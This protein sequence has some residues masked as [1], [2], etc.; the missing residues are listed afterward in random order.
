MILESN[1]N[2]DKLGS[3][4]PKPFS[5]DDNP[6]NIAYPVSSTKYKTYPQHTQMLP[7][8]CLQ[9][10]FHTEELIKLLYRS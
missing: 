3:E 7:P 5:M 9:Y 6:E 1:I 10:E 2:D 4:N 8:L